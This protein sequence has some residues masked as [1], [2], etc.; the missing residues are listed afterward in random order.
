MFLLAADAAPW[1]LYQFPEFPFPEAL[2]PETEYPPGKIIREYIQVMA[3]CL[4]ES[5]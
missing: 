3:M 4:L 2:R 5:F 1:E